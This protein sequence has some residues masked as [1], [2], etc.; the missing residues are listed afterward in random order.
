MSRPEE[1][2]CRDAALASALL[3]GIGI[4]FFGSGLVL[5]NQESCTGVCEFAGL[6]MLYSGGPISALI[7]FFTDSVIVAWPLEVLL[8]VVLGFT[9]ARWGAGTGRSTWA[10][11]TGALVTA[12]LYGLG[13]SQ[14]VEL[15]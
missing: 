4:A 2:G 13:L 7:G 1:P 3:L 8:W 12:I 10:F 6:A 9:A 15:A 5:V 14:F 11:V